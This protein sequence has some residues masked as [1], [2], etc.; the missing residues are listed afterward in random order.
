MS[1]LTASATV[2]SRTA[3]WQ[4][5]H[6]QRGASPSSHLFRPH[7]H[8]WPAWRARL[9]AWWGQWYRGWSREWSCEQCCG[10]CHRWQQGP[11]SDNAAGT[12]GPR[13]WTRNAGVVRD[14]CGSSDRI[15]TI[16]IQRGAAE[17]NN[18]RFTYPASARDRTIG[19][20]ITSRV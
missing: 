12:G 3:T 11:V 6:P 13:S 16:H 9:T 17:F 15:K 7:S 5:P 10:W 20:K 19:G 1:M 2:K 8:L 18:C 14:D 4:M